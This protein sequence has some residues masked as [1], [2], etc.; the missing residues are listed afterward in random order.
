MAMKGSFV[1]SKALVLLEPHHQIVWR[2]KQDIRFEVSYRSVAMESLYSTATADWATLIR[3]SYPL[4]IDT[5][6]VFYSHSRLGYV[7]GGS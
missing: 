6:F 5:V 4:C 7:E 1:F 3:V 2:H